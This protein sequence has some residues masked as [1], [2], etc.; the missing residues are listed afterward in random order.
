MTLEAVVKLLKSAQVLDAP[1]SLSDLTLA[2]CEKAG[3]GHFFMLI[4]ATTG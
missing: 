2:Y 1:R 3:F 4:L